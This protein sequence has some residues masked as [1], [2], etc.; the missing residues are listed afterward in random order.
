MFEKLKSIWN[1]A[2]FHALY[3]K[4]PFFEGWFYR[5]TDSAQR[6]SIAVIPG[7]F[8]SASSQEHAFIMTLDG[9]TNHTEYYTFDK[10]QLNASLHSPAFSIGANHFDKNRVHMEL[11]S[12]Y[13]DLRFSDLHPWPLTWS[14]PGTMGKYAFVPF[15]QCYHAVLSFS[16]TLTGSLNISQRRVNFDNGKGYIEK[17]WGSG[18]PCAYVW[19]QSQH[20]KAKNCSL[21]A[22]VAHIPWLKHY[23]PGFIIGLAYADRF[24]SF[25]SYNGSVIRT[26]RITKDRVSILA[27]KQR[28]EIDI[29]A[30]RKP[31]GILYAPVKD[32]MQPAVKET[33]NSTISMTLRQNNKILLQTEG[34][35]GGL[36]VYG[37][38]NC[39]LK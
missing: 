17:D 38:I 8:R 15:M 24:Y 35:N 14:S 11:D 16:H 10:S 5:F 30:G 2:G 29:H 4:A 3:S 13:G 21:M 23:F 26:C 32:R 27:Q 9:Q 25:T 19:L 12:L 28:Y 37:D 18:F 33:L 31:G 6:N 7:F 39:L 36:D 1:P 22:S 20:F 34:N